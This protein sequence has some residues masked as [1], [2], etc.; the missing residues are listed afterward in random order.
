MI[1]AAPTWSLED[2]W[3]AGPPFR[4]VLP[5]AKRDRLAVLAAA[6]RRRRSCAVMGCGAECL[7][8]LLVESEEEVVLCPVHQLVRLDGSAIGGQPMLAT[9]AW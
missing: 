9:A 6:L 3:A 2:N 4:L 1:A 7:P 5:R 8:V